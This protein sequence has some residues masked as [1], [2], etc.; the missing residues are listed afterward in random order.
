MVGSADFVDFLWFLWQVFGG[1]VFFLWITAGFWRGGVF[2]R[3]ME[4]YVAD[5]LE[6]RSFFLRITASFGQCGGG[7]IEN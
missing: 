6:R 3:I 1:A 7:Q 2:L 5:E 4:N